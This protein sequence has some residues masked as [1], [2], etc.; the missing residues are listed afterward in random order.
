M[1]SIL[2]L[3]GQ[4]G[5][6]GRALGRVVLVVHQRAHGWCLGVRIFLYVK[7]SY[8]SYLTLRAVASEVL[9]IRR[10][11]LHT[12]RSLTRSKVSL[13]TRVYTLTPR[14]YADY[15]PTRHM[16]SRVSRHPRTQRYS[17]CS[18]APG[19]LI[20]ATDIRA[21][22]GRTPYRGARG[23]VN[24]EHSPPRRG[25]DPAALPGAQVPSWALGRRAA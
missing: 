2:A 19:E 7:V 15:A 10:R 21:F 6:V 18:A 8:F 23:R 5:P 9:A 3:F 20:Q 22:G 1:W 16:T 25:R 13:L 24:V 17:Q 4:C 14:L 11:S 12:K